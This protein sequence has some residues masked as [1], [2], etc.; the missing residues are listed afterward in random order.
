MRTA[1][2]AASA[3]TAAEAVAAGLKGEQIRERLHE[4]RCRAVRAA[5]REAEPGAAP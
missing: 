2:A 3:V 4:A 1:C 5:L